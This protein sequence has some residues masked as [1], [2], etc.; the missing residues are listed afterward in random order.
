MQPRKMFYAEFLGAN[1]KPRYVGEGALMPWQKEQA[2]LF[3]TPADA[4]AALAKIAAHHRSGSYARIGSRTVII[5]LP[6][7]MAAL[8]FEG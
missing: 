5:A 6:A 7:V 3:A 4:K 1:G 8:G 2:K